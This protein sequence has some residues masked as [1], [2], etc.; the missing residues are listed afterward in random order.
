MSGAATMER[1]NAVV[2]ARDEDQECDIEAPPI[3]EPLCLRLPEAAGLAAELCMEVG[4]H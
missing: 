4:F 3:I 1:G 2:P